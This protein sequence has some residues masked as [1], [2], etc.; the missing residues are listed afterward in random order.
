MKGIDGLYTAI[1]AAIVEREKGNR[2]CIDMTDMIDAVTDEVDCYSASIDWYV[3]KVISQAITIALWQS[4]Y[5]SVVH[6]KGLFVN[7]QNAKKPEY[8]VKL[9]NNAKLSEEQK[10]K[11]VNMM[12]K[13]IQ[14]AGVDRQLFFDAKGHIHEEISEEQLI[15][16]LRKDAI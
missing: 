1:N 15:E 8:L 16:M 14:D 6:G 9:F 5:R 11:V 13:E 2:L 3:H 4:G 12:L 7:P 10:Q